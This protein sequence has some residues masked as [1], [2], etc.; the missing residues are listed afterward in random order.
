MDYVLMVFYFGGIGRFM[1]SVRFDDQTA[2]E[3]A[4]TAI[5]D[6][7]EERRGLLGL[8][9]TYAETMHMICVPAAT[10]PE[11]TA[12]HADAAPPENSMSR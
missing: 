4:R 9:K 10:E 12:N 5:Y 11:E 3:A 6:S 2:C 8:G 7:Y 1:H